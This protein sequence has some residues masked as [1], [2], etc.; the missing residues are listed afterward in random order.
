[1]TGNL[2]LNS[3]AVIAYRAGNTE[4]CTLIDEA[5]KSFLPVIV[6]GELYFGALK[7]SQKQKNLDAIESFKKYSEIIVVD[8]YIATE[9]ATIRLELKKKG[10]PIP[11][12]DIWIAATTKTLDVSLLSNDAHFNYVDGIKV[13]KWQQ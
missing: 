3:N 7:S 4:V 6:L 13:I 2:V 9:Y 12:N 10:T 5:G 8:E 11:E 1:M